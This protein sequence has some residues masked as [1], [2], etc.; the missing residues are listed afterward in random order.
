V[1]PERAER[2]GSHCEVSP[3]SRD[4]DVYFIILKKKP[5]EFVSGVAPTAQSPQDLI[6]YIYL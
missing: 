6:F 1:P 3:F 2:V 4:F 5:I